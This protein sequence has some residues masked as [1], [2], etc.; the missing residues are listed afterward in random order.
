MMRDESTEAPCGLGMVG[1]ASM[2]V[3][4]L[5]GCRSESESAVDTVVWFAL[6]SCRVVG[7]GFML[8]SLRYGD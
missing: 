1:A 8:S 7:I 3:I 6:V 5:S 4:L 2:R